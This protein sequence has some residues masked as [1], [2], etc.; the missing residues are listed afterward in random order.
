MEKTAKQSGRISE[1]IWMVGEFFV[2]LLAKKRVLAGV[3]NKS[4]REMG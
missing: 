4:A 2:L 3:V 1:S